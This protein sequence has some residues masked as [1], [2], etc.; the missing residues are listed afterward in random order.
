MSNGETNP[1][2]VILTAIP[3]EY[4][5]VRMHI[6]NPRRVTHKGSIYQHGTFPAEN[7]IWDIL[8]VETDAGNMNAAVAAERAINYFDPVLVLFVGVAG[9]L[10]DV[11]LGDVVAATKVYGYESGKANTNFLTRPDVGNS[12]FRLV[13]LARA[14]GRERDWRQRI[15]GASSERDPEVYVKPIAAG[16]KVVDSTRSEI[17][18]FLRT[19]YGDAVAVEMEG[20]GFLQAVY[21]NWQVDAL[22]I[23]GISDLIEGKSKA[24]A[25]NSQDIAARHASAFAFEILAKLDIK[26]IQKNVTSIEASVQKETP[27]HAEATTT[28]DTL[29]EQLLEP[30]SLSD[31]ADTLSLTEYLTRIEEMSMRFNGKLE[32]YPDLCE[33][34]IELMKK[35]DNFFQQNYKLDSSSI[36]LMTSNI[37][38]EIRKLIGDLHDL[39]RTCTPSKQKQQYN[40]TR[41]K[42]YKSFVNFTTQLTQFNN[43]A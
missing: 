24:D 9:G 41:T 15:K 39:A 4:M 7:W 3:V 38:E 23:R 43:M 28:K 19:N 1:H 26:E 29:I 2:A 11:A 32:V 36:G 17:Y 42:V 12:T 27:A 25:N 8:I 37:I 16:E 5:A 6:A 18:T 21:Q 31:Q 40:N 30:E 14:E 10:K 13:E 33:N 34:A 20:R 22:V 35:L